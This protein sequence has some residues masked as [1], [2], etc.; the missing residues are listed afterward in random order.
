M[1]TIQTRLPRL[2]RR[3]NVHPACRRALLP[4][5]VFCLFLASAARAADVSFYG[6]F[7]EQAF[8]Q[9]NPVAPRLSE[10]E[11]PLF[12]TAFVNQTGTNTVTS[13]TVRLSPAGDPLA[14]QSDGSE[15]GIEAPFDGKLEFDAT[16]PAGDYLLDLVTLN[17]GS[18]SLTLTLS[19]DAYPNPPRISNYTAAQ[20]IDSAAVFTVQWDAL[21]GGTI[22]D[23]IKVEIEE[24]GSG[25]FV[26]ET[27]EPGALDALDGTD[28]SVLIPAD[29]FMPG[30]A[31]RVYLMFVKPTDLDTTS[32]PGATGIAGY[33]CESDIVIRTAGIDSGDA[34]APSVS[35]SPDG[36]NGEV[37]VN[38]A[39]AFLF[40]EPMDT[41]IVPTSIAWTGVDGADFT[42]TWNS[43][44][45]RLFAIH[46]VALP[47]STEI[48]WTLN[49]AG[50][51][52]FDDL[53]GNML[54]TSTGSFTTAA[55]S[56][57]GS[58]D[59]SELHLVKGR[60]F[61]QDATS[62][63]ADGVYFLELGA[64]LTG[65]N[66]VTLV[67]LTLPGGGVVTLEPEFYD[68]NLE[69]E[70]EYTFKADL[71]SFFPNGS[72]TITLHTVHD[73][74]QTIFLTLSSD[75]YPNAPTLTNLTAAQTIDP[76]VN[77]PLPWNA[78]SGGT[79]DDFIFAEV[80][81]VSANNFDEVFWSPDPGEPG[82]LNG[83]SLNV[84]I[85]AYTLA[86]G[87]DY[88]T[89]LGFVKFVDSDD[90]TYPGMQA[91][92]GF[93]SETEMQMHAAGEI[94]TPQIG[95]L[96]LNGGQVQLRLTGERNVPCLLKCSTDLVNWFDLGTYWPNTPLPGTFVSQVDLNFAALGPK[97]F[98]RASENL[99][100]FGGGDPGGG[101]L[102][103][104]LLF[105]TAIE[106]TPCSGGSGSLYYGSAN[107]I[108]VGAG[109][110]FDTLLLR[111]QEPYANEPVVRLHGTLETSFQANLDCY[112]GGANLTTLT[113]SPQSGG[114]YGSFDTGTSSGS[115]WVVTQTGNVSI[116]GR[117][118]DSSNNPVANAVVSTSLDSQIATSD[119][120]GAFFLQTITPA[121]F[122]NQSTYEILVNAA[123]Q[124][125]NTWGAYPW[126]QSFQTP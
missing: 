122:G 7:K 59:V 110:S 48:S 80:E 37:P 27:G 65:Y 120:N 41:T 67:T 3:F 61:N 49:P 74:I 2:P 31:Y 70:A 66:T 44:G 111:G 20:S 126:Q 93:I 22:N 87:R 4:A 60:G 52:A 32:Y 29:T 50:F 89:I 5:L 118:T 15:L 78:F 6:V 109:G 51:E 36:F 23:F 101:D 107:N 114:Y 82:A 46:D 72:Y 115:F 73:G 86:P 45:D 75:T 104:S 99:D 125:N 113:A 9:D 77:F 12:F 76:A 16:Y 64:E 85:P 14:L 71:D 96:G 18:P 97:R 112:P 68:Q 26:F 92:A 103:W 63:S 24:L 95:A 10:E 98:Y 34:T 8:I 19:A 43:R 55:T 56:N 62:V 90:T 119:S 105:T 35:A 21:Q 88:E 38:S 25:N 106:V 117:V 83:Q 33:I 40:S 116:H 123:S 121:N 57:F 1:N 102:G 47:I 100:P 108:E 17:D 53:N 28:I 30:R 54:P 94:I 91:L 39:I 42:Y 124:G 11:G 58:I 79:I 84:T 81:R 69:F 13:G